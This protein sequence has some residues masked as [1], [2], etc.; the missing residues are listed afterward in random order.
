MGEFRGHGS[1]DWLHRDFSF[2][3]P[4]S[5]RST[6]FGRS[7]YRDPRSGTG[8]VEVGVEVEGIPDR[9]SHVL[10]VLPV[11]G[12]DLEEGADDG[13]GAFGMLTVTCGVP[14]CVFHI[15]GNRMSLMSVGSLDE[16]ASGLPSLPLFLFLPVPHGKHTCK[17]S[18]LLIQQQWEGTTR[19][20]SQWY[21]P[22]TA[23]PGTA[24]AGTVGKDPTAARCGGGLNVPEMYCSRRLTARLFSTP[25]LIILHL[26]V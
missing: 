5:P 13:A 8:P 9:P 12:E 17:V 2:C 19:E 1:C 6:T 22:A 24:V 16:A 15:V 3:S 14:C 20:F 25:P 10:P 26:H 4:R 7:G 21:E 18:L 11:L 23:K